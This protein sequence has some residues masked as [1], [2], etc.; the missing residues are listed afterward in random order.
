MGTILTIGYEGSSIDDFVATLML[1][2]IQVIIDVREIPLSR[3]RGFSK[4]AL[5]DALEDIGVEY[6]HLRDLGDPKPGREAA[7]RGDKKEFER[8]YRKHL[9]EEAAQAAL[10]T[11]VQIAGKSR[12]CLL[13]FERDPSDCHR[14]IIAKEITKLETAKIEHLGVRKGLAEE[15]NYGKLEAGRAYAFG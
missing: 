5:S 7:R 8:I 6:V 2:D 10:E 13:C 14:T 4:R 1:S 15:K 9:G 11:A 3:K 12:S